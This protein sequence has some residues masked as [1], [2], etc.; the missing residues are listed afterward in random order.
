MVIELFNFHKFTA[1]K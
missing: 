1:E